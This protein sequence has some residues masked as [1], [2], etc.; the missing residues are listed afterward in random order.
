MF[1]PS[2]IYDF[3]YYYYYKW[4]DYIVNRLQIMILYHMNYF[5][6]LYNLI[7]SLYKYIFKHV[8]I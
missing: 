6:N 2:Q 5:P 1:Y 7:L 3:F 8:Y 4:I